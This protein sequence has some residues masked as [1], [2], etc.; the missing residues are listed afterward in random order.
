MRNPKNFLSSSS[1]LVPPKGSNSRIILLENFNQ[2]Y[3]IDNSYLSTI[4]IIDQIR[5]NL[6]KFSIPYDLITK[7]FS[8]H[9]T[10]IVR[11]CNF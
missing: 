8:L 10:I 6:L 11:K 2:Y 3:I 7:L 5:I 4:I 9:Y 1:N